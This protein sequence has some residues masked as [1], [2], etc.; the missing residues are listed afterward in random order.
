MLAKSFLKYA[1]KKK[2]NQTFRGCHLLFVFAFKPLTK[3][4]QPRN[5]YSF[6]PFFNAY[7]QKLWHSLDYLRCTASSNFRTKGRHFITF[8]GA[9]FPLFPSP[10]KACHAGNVLLQM[11]AKY[12][13]VCVLG[14]RHCHSL[15]G[16]RLKGKG[17]YKRACASSFPDLFAFKHPP[18]TLEGSATSYSSFLSNL[19]KYHIKVRSP[20]CTVQTF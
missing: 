8:S 7:F 15:L 12:L 2:E 11:D 6:P 17:V 10:S 20:L 1:L 18:R 14:A 13:L 3:R 5:V 4:K 19:P 9:F 16:R